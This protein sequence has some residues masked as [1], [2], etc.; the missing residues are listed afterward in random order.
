MG[1][2]F[3]LIVKVKVRAR[4]YQTPLPT[5]SLCPI[6]PASLQSGHNGRLHF[7]NM[8]GVPSPGPLPWL[9]SLLG[10]LFPICPRGSRPLLPLFLQTDL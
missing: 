6:S 7:S 8:P 4:A 3:F 5:S 1:P 10:K 2:H 9:L